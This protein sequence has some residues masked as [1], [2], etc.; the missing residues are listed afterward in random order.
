MK[1][2]E[3]VKL[4]NQDLSGEIEAILVYMRDSFVTEICEPSRE[5]EEIAKDEM[6][7]AEKLSEV[8]VDLGGIPTM[9]HRELDF[10]GRS[11]KS[12]L[13]RLIHLEQEAI[14][15]YTDHIARI[16]DEKIKRL[17]THIL[18]EEE[19]HLEEFREQLAQLKL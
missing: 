13:K 16:P 9:E 11:V 3:I 19:E 1:N 4:L 18:H 12:Y 8:I 17:L 10:G 6:R 2:A 14:A 15:M 7:H 5:M